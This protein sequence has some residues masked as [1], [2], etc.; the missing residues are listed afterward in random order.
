M[1]CVVV[2]ICTPVSSLWNAKNWPYPAVERFEALVSIIIPMSF[3]EVL[4]VVTVYLHAGIPWQ[5]VA[6]LLSVLP[7]I[8]CLGRAS[9]S[10]ICSNRGSRLVDAVVIFS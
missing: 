7:R 3:V 10:G 6:S 4:M 5:D 9:F 8:S 2:S 1:P